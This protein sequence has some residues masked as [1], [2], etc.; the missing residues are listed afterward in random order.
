MHAIS[1]EDAVPHMPDTPFEQAELT[2]M[3]ELGIVRDAAPGYYWIDLPAFRAE[4]LARE[5][6]LAVVAGF[7]ALVIAGA[8]LLLYRA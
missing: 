5:K 8:L 2:R 1:P 6:R 7:S 3:R 4:K